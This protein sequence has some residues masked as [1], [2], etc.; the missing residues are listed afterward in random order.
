[1]HIGRHWLSGSM[2]QETEFSQWSGALSLLMSWSL[3]V[4]VPANYL[5]FKIFLTE[6]A[7]R[8]HRPRSFF[9]GCKSSQSH[10]IP[11]QN[12]QISRNRIRHPSFQDQGKIW[13]CPDEKWNF[14]HP[15][16]RLWTY[17]G[18]H[19]SW[20]TMWPCLLATAAFHPH[21]AMMMKTLMR[22]WKNFEHFILSHSLKAIW[23]R[24]MIWF[25][26]LNQS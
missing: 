25:S 10:Q 4:G 15:P 21:K 23:F 16:N 8:T 17:Q 7:W 18:I 22:R 3:L 2:T 13:T 1:M 9:S 24:W 6:T 19:W 20:M 12:R 26:D 5:S 14:G 11:H